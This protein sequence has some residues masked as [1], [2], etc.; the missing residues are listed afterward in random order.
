MRSLLVSW[1]GLRPR[2][3]L[4]P[5]WRPLARRG[6]H[7][8]DGPGARGARA[9]IAGNRS[10]EHVALRTRLRS[11]D[12]AEPCISDELRAVARIVRPETFPG[13]THYD[14]ASRR[15]GAPAA[16]SVRGS[17]TRVRWRVILKGPPERRPDA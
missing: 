1:Q 7:R 10:V 4:R 17:L 13:R 11:R 9:E 15:G 3:L 12:S 6:A 16:V 8:P 5:P 14:I 2:S